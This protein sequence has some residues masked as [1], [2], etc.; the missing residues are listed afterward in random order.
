MGE[1]KK[2]YQQYDQVTKQKQGR[3]NGNVVQNANPGL[4]LVTQLENFALKLRP[5]KKMSNFKY[6]IMRDIE[7]KVFST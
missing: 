4:F 5:S 2:D 6:L 7:K 1:I 3:F